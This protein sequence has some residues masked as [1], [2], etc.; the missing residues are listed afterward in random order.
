MVTVLLVGARVAPAGGDPC[1]TVRAGAT[2]VAAG[3]EVVIATPDGT[4][5]GVRSLRAVLREGTAGYAAVFVAGGGNGV[6]ALLGDP[7]ALAALRALHAAGLSPAILCEG[8]AALGAAIGEAAALR[9]ALAAG[10]AA[11]GPPVRPTA[12]RSVAGADPLPSRA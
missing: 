9:E 1:E 7:E 6:S 8:H 4:A 5:V 12:R 2:L 11:R 3:H 10:E